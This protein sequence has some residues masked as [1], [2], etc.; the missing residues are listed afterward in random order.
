MNNLRRFRAFEAPDHYEFKDPDSGILYTGK[1]VPEVVD[2]INKYRAQ[3]LLEPLEQLPAVITEY[4][5]GLPENCNKCEKNK[6]LTR[7]IFTYVKGGILLAKNAYFKV[8]VN[9]EEA[10]KRGQQCLGCVHNVF[11]DKGPFLKY[12]DDI[13]IKQVGDRE[14]SMAKDLGNCAACTC[15]LKS[16]VFL[17][18]SLPKFP[19]DQLQKM[20]AVKCWQLKLSQQE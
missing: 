5:C 3:N 20:K 2:R 11:P 6:D 4:T 15:V 18:G 14:V 17:G 16:K 13:A 1:T 7:S 9:Q 8:F 10:E 12:T 19:E